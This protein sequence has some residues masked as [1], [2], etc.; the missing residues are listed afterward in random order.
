MKK[1]HRERRLASARWTFA[2][3]KSVQV[4]EVEV[5]PVAVSFVS[6]AHDRIFEEEEYDRVPQGAARVP[7]IGSWYIVLQ[8]CRI[9][10]VNKMRYFWT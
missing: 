10:C 1:N 6:V 7:G 4:G 2:F 9:T 3:E 5:C 8:V